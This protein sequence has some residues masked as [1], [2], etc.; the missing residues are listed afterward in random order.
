MKIVI[1]FPLIQQKT[2]NVG[3]ETS[4]CYILKFEKI[5]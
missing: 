2:W 5:N 3:V 4:F 1:L